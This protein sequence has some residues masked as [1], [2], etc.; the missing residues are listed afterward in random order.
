MSSNACLQNLSVLAKAVRGSC[1]AM[2]F[3]T[4]D[5]MLSRNWEI[6]PYSNVL[7]IGYMNLLMI[8]LTI[9]LVDLSISFKILSKLVFHFVNFVVLSLTILHWMSIF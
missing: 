2:L 6:F 9:T 7:Q 4:V 3:K 1:L 8:F 5:V